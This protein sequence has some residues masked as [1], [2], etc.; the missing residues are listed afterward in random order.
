MYRVLILLPEFAGLARDFTVAA[1]C[2]IAIQDSSLIVVSPE[3]L[4]DRISKADKFVKTL[5]SIFM[6][7]LRDTH[8]TYFL[9]F[10][11]ISIS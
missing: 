3:T 8:K 9:S 6:T 10:F 2:A 11:Y 7:N 4:E 1:I 5:L